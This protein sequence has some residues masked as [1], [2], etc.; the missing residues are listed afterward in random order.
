VR[1]RSLVAVLVACAALASYFRPASSADEN[2]LDPRVAT[3]M[4]SCLPLPKVAP[5]QPPRATQQ[6][7][8]LAFLDQSQATAAPTD[9][10]TD[11]PS[12]APSLAP[13]TIPPHLPPPPPGPGQLLPPTPLPTG[14][15]P[16]TPPPLPTPTPVGTAPPQ[17]LVRPT[18]TPFIP[19]KG[20]GATPLPQPS[21]EGPSPLPVLRPFDMVIMADEVHGF[22][23]AGQPGDASGNVHI[24]YVDGQIVGDNAHYDGEHT[25]TLTGHA[26]L[27]DRTEDSLLYAD[28]IK[29]DTITRQSVLVNGRGESIAGVSHGKMHYTATDLQTTS[30]GTIHGNHASFTTCEN[31]KGGYHVE[32]NTID[33]TPGD[34]LIARKAVVFLGPLAI[35]Y[36][37]FLVI[38]LNQTR[39][40]R[41]PTTFLPIIGYDDAE[42]YYIKTRIGFS[43]SDTYYGYYRVEYFTK[44]GLGLGY[45]AVI[46]S[47]SRKHYLTIDSYTISDHVAQARETNVDIQDTETFSQRLRGQFGI[48]YVGDFGPSIALPASYNLT[49]TIAH[50]GNASAETIT[51]NQFKQG[52]LQSSFNLGFVDSIKLSPTVQQAFNI[53]YGNLAN[54]VQDSG[55]LHLNT[56]THWATHAADFDL[57]YDKTDYTTQPFGYDRLPE[58]TVVPHFDFHDS[59][60]DP[61]FQLQI[62]QYT[63]PQNQF[64]T[65][66]VDAELNLPV[67]LKLGSSD[68]QGNWDIHQ[69]YY[70]TG[71]LKAFEM[72]D[73]SL[74]TPLGSNFVNTLTYN[75]QHPIGPA[76]VPFELLDQLSGGSKAAQEIIRFYNKDIY[77][78]SLSGGTDFDEEA[79]PVAY[80]LNARP[81]PRSL[82]VIGGYWQPGPGNGFGQT[83]VQVLTPFGRDTTLQFSTNINWKSK[84]Q[85]QDKNVYLSKIIGDCYRIDMSY[86]EDY[87]SFNLNLVILAFPN[88]GGFGFN[89]PSSILP[90][91]FGGL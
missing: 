51:V 72:Q 25:I 37:P 38:P 12:A 5:P 71:D 45:T 1:A 39:D 35:L 15:A 62:G 47:K 14:T 40:P 85:L 27:I 29:F 70:G 34:K 2:V 88:Q 79:Q 42:G 21:A 81:S 65:E 74:T 32:S 55:T 54:S 57:V 50:Q 73:L 75:E 80:Q 89:G 87:K 8:R 60:I 53:S 22:N 58:L 26:Y 16:V 86:N 6:V 78:L 24:F 46:G 9:A 61:Q 28:S 18:G 17:Y 59:I 69:D 77:S 83:N 67:F 44:R 30:S 23:R 36:L 49:G 84:G 20:S 33:V 91:S 66:R 10:P 63:E 41:K 3:I 82:L 68:F 31:P 52:D 4:N 56:D 48:D 13:P 11:Q 64:S 7:R 90:Q 19:G 43:P 76:N